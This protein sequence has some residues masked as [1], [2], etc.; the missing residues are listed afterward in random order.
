MLLKT[1]KAP[2]LTPAPGVFN[3]GYLDT[4]LNTLRIYF[5]Y[6]DYIVTNLIGRAGGRHIQFPYGAFSARTTQSVAV[7]N[8]P[9][10]ATLP[11][12]DAA[13]GVHYN[14]GNGLHVD[15]TGVYNLQFSIQLTNDDTQAHDAALWLRKDGVDVPWSSSV[16]TVPSTHGGIA[17][18]QV[19]AANFY[20]EL[21]AG[22]YV[23]LWWATNSLQVTMNALPPITTPFVN[24]GAPAVVVTLT[25]V[26]NLE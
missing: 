11:T 7:I 22:Q 21:A 6:L 2:A 3:K 1:S 24:P 18:Y 25:F 20:I 9:T 10:L 14:P 19:L 16:V 12:T 17:G 8:T 15:Y 23:E 13:V 26:S 4:L 5:S